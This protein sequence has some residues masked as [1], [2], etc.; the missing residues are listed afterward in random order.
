MRQISKLASRVAHR[1]VD[2]ILVVSAFISHKSSS[3]IVNA[4]KQQGVIFAVL[5]RGHDVL[6]VRRAVERFVP[7]LS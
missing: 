1:G 2:L 6:A 5:E 4:C 7:C 3:K